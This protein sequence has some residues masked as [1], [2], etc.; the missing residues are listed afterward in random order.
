MGCSGFLVGSLIDCSRRTVADFRSSTGHSTH[1]LAVDL[2]QGSL[3]LSFTV[4]PGSSNHI[5]CWHRTNCTGH[6]VA[7]GRS[8]DCHTFDFSTARRSQLSLS[9]REAF[10]TRWIQTLPELAAT[11]LLSQA[12]ASPRLPYLDPYS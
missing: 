7:N 5:G 3:P 9:S 1:Y 10:T 8:P 11:E 4:L 6:I 12:L 2:N